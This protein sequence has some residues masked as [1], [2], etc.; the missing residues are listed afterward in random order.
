MKTFYFHPEERGESKMANI[1]D[2]AQAAGRLAGHGI[3]RDQRAGIR[4]SG[5]A[6][7]R[8]AGDP[9]AQLPAQ[10][11]GASTAYT[12]DKN[13]DR[14]CAQHSECA[15][16]RG[17]FWHRIR[18]RGARLS[19]AGRRYAQPALDRVALPQ[20]DPAA[21]GGRDHLH[22]R[23]YDAKAHPAGRRSVPA[24]DGRAEFRKQQHPLRFDRQR[25]PLPAPP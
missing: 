21:A 8:A 15:D 11:T 18:C 9:G 1:N 2:V 23:Q 17:G 13:R 10:C 12:G 16:A 25:C 24:R 7:P 19:G 3:P 6:R 4:P 22:V 20:C 14:H 5:N